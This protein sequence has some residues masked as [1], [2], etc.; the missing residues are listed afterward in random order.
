MGEGK[1][2]APGWRPGQ[3]WLL[4]KEDASGGFGYR[5]NK[6]A[7][8]GSWAGHPG[9]RFDSVSISRNETRFLG[10]LFELEGLSGKLAR[11]KYVMIF[12]HA[13]RDPAGS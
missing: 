7:W 1:L 6:T 4:G 8:F 11:I 10:I 12:A 2:R 5:P 3:V 13:V 9:T